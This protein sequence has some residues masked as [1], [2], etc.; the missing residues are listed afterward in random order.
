[1]NRRGAAYQTQLNYSYSNAVY[2]N[3]SYIR[4]RTASL[5]W[6]LPSIIFKSVSTHNSKIF[7]SAQNLFTISNYE[8]TDPEIQNYYSLP[9]LRTIAIGVQLNF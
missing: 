2:G 3:A 8:G 6:K 1:T 9:A 5:S 7:V 4:L